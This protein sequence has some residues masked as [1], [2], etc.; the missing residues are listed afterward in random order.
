M[1]YIEYPEIRDM[2]RA[3]AAGREDFIYNPEN[4]RRR[5]MYVEGYV[6]DECGWNT[7]QAVPSCL[8]GHVF[9]ANGIVE[10]AGWFVR[11]G[12]N[13]IEAIGMVMDLEDCEFS[14]KAIDFINFSQGWQDKGFTWGEAIDKASNGESPWNYR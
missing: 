14:D 6:K 7:D 1:R 11:T 5:C 13:E 9:L 2:A 12:N 10:D 3:V 4:T 8:W